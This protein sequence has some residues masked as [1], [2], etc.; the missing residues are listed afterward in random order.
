LTAMLHLWW[1][2]SPLLISSALQAFI[3]SQM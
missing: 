2:C 3:S 1:L